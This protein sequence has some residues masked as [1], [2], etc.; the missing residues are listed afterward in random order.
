MGYEPLTRQ[1]QGVNGLFPADGWKVVQELIQA[2]SSLEVVDEVANRDPRACKD[3][4]FAH[5]VR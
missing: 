1:L 5:D 2:L 4:S 3:R